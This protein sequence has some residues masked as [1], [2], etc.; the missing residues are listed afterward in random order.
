MKQ[1][2][3]DRTGYV[4]QRKYMIY[5]YIYTGYIIYYVFHPWPL[6]GPS[7][8]LVPRGC[9]S[10]IEQSR[11]LDSCAAQKSISFKCV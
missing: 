6:E 10:C 5:I 3:W 2:E 11:K 9:Y 8:N 7:Q 1:H 4:D